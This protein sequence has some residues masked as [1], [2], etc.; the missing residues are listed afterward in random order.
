MPFLPRK[1]PS[2]GLLVLLSACGSDGP[3][4]PASTPGASVLLVTLDTTRAD[5]LGCYGHAN[6]GT[7]NLDGLAA[8]GARFGR[9]YATVPITLPSHASIMTGGYPPYHGLRDNGLFVRRH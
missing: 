3:G 1:I 5:R 7:P 2:L 8:R 4:E 6:A 9:A